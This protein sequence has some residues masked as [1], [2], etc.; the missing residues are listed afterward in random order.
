MKAIIITVI[1]IGFFVQNS[2]A[3]VTDSVAWQFFHMG[4][5]YS[6]VKTGDTIVGNDTMSVYNNSI[7]L[8]EGGDTTFYYKNGQLNFLYANHAQVG[9]V[10]HPLNTSQFVYGDTCYL[11]LKVKYIDSVQISGQWLTRFTLYLMNAQGVTTYPVSVVEKIGVYNGYGN[12]IGP[13]YETLAAMCDGE[14]VMDYPPACLLSYYSE[15][16]NYSYTIPDQAT[17]YLEIEENLIENEPI[18]QRKDNHIVVKWSGAAINLELY[19]VNGQKIMESKK[20]ILYLPENHGLY[21]LHIQS[22]GKLRIIK[23]MN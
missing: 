4:G 15:A 6:Y 18:I 9:D 7:F 14:A 8:K 16:L 20:N 10:W 1:S 22:E 19:S 21:F 13:L 17:C 11:S 23:L 5:T 12:S 3:Q 2:G